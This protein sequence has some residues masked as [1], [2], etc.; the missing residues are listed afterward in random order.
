MFVRVTMKSLLVH[1]DILEKGVVMRCLL[2][3]YLALSCVSVFAA[4][5]D[6]LNCRVNL[7]RGIQT[8]AFQLNQVLTP[9]RKTIPYPSSTERHIEVNQGEIPFEIF[10]GWDKISA[11]ITYRFAA[12]KDSSGKT[13][14]A[15]HWN[16]FEGLIET[17]DGTDTLDC[18]D[19]DQM[20]DPFSTSNGRWQSAVI[21]DQ[22]P[23][24]PEGYILQGRMVNGNDTLTV[25]CKTY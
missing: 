8:Q 11:K 1:E 17:I 22:T 3:I 18:G 25:V 12:L 13:V 14:E 21:R 2:V 24:W 23:T 6:Q 16:C 10:L 7:K 20:S 5:F 9:S 4:N 15:S 19:K